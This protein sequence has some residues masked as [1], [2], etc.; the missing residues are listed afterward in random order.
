M[1]NITLLIKCTKL[2]ICTNLI[3]VYNVG[4]IEGGHDDINKNRNCRDHGKHSKYEVESESVVLGGNRHNGD[5]RKL[6]DMEVDLIE[7]NI[8]LLLNCFISKF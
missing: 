3:T 8:F 4:I 5:S 1:D 6:T 7:F 2:N